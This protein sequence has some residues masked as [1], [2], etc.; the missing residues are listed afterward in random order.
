[1]PLEILEAAYPVMFRQWALRTDSG[2]A[3][4]HRGGLG[5]V[6]EIELLEQQANAF[7]FGERGR[8]APPGVLGGGEGA[9][10]RFR[11]EQDDGEHAPPLASKMVGIDL[12]RGQAVRLETPG[13]GG[14]GPA[15]E[16]DPGAVA[17]DVRLGYVSAEAARRDYGVALDGSGKLDETATRTLR[18]AVS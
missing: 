14:Y 11:Y 15:M 18:S 10:N 1:P 3:G 6:Y 7:L 4:R 12:A 5:A 8:F 16:R 9:L 17:E 2:G 13:G